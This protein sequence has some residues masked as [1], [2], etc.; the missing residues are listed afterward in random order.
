VWPALGTG[1]FLVTAIEMSLMQNGAAVTLTIYKN[2]TLSR[3]SEK[4]WRKIFTAL[5]V[6]M[7]LDCE[8]VKQKQF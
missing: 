1:P 7:L 4:Y 5:L 8:N 6:Y 2:Y 3:Q